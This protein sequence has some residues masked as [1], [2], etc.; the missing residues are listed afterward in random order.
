MRKVTVILSLLLSLAAKAQIVFK[1]EV[2][3]LPVIA[4]ESFRVQYVLE[5]IETD[6]DLTPP[7]F[8]GFRLVNGPDIYHTNRS[9][10]FKN[11]VYTLVATKP[12]KFI[13]H[14]ATAIVNG[15]LITSNNA[16]IEVIPGAVKDENAS[17]YFLQPGEDPYEKMQKNLFMKVMVNKRT[18]YVG[19]PV[20]ATFKLYSRLQ[21]KSDI[22][23]NPGFY[24]FSVQDIISLDDNVSSTETVNGK[25]FDVHTV[26]SVQLYPLQEGLFTIDAMEVMNKVEFS[27]SAVNKKPE[28]EVVEGFFE[29]KEQSSTPGNTIMYE[30]SISTEKIAIHVKPHPAKNKPT[31]FTGATGRFSI[32]AVVE[33]NG[34]AKNEEGDLIIIIE[35]KGNFTQ[36]SAPVIQWPDGME[37]FD[38]AM[39]DSLDKTNTPLRGTRTFRFPFVAAKAGTYI[40]PAVSLV[41]FD[42]DS[43]NYKAV[44]TSPVEIKISEQESGIS[45]AIAQ[46]KNSIEN[47]YAPLWWAGA[48]LLLLLVAA[49]RWFSKKRKAAA[50]A[51]TRDE[52]KISP[53]IDGLLK[54]AYNAMEKNDSQFYILL[55]KAIWD[56]LCFTLN[57]YGSNVNKS[58]LRQALEA[59]G[60]AEDQSK[61]ILDILQE[62]EAAAFTKAEFIYDKQELLIR[63]KRALE[64]IKV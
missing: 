15:R 1:T 27:K 12:G 31:D 9:K 21:S 35:G 38:A 26:R 53:T 5:G 19:E 49:T 44:S 47:S 14:G 52:N 22:V 28:Q 17:A 3:Q 33:K 62:C 63:T 42:I 30:N 36:L 8:T 50:Q 48:G 56:H 46:K 64:Q 32:R 18:C 37:G 23:K 45:P 58:G 16:V 41:F 20:V 61:N 24:G 34:L 25:I 11:V 60:L 2:P 43:N 59:K 6:D 29:N 40:I 4:G 39:K 7:L 13:I 54:P 57:L 55:Q 51:M 10:F